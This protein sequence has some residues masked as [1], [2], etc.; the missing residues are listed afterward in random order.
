M[1]LTI[2]QLH[3]ESGFRLATG[4]P[5]P[6]CSSRMVG[7]C[8]SLTWVYHVPSGYTTTVGPCSQ[9]PRHAELVT[10]TS[11][12]WTPRSIIPILN[13]ISIPADPEA[14][15]EGLGWPGG[16]EFVHTRMWYLG[17]GIAAPFLVVRGRRNERVA[18]R[19]HPDKDTSVRILVQRGRKD[20]HISRQA[21]GSF[22]CLTPFMTH[23]R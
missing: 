14:P 2:C 6:M 3:T 10:N 1:K 7:T 11:P 21:S 20:R 19:S 18:G 12:G 23:S 8:S 16:R 13:A 17:F 15:Q 4:F 5:F 22:Q 9:G